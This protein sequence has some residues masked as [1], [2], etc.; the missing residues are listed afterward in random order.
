MNKA[1][2]FWNERRIQLKENLEQNRLPCCVAIP[3]SKF[4]ENV[5]G[6]IRTANAFLIKEIVL[7]HGVYNKAAT[8]GTAKWEN[9]EITQ[10]VFGY[11]K[12]QGYKSVA[13]EQ[14]PRS[15]PIWDFEFP[16]NTA[17]FI[18]HEV[19]GMND[20]M[21]EKCDYVIEIPQFGLVESLNV[22]TATSI[23]LYEYS[24]QHRK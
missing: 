20:E 9:I 8:A 22:A 1:L 19:H 23:A 13:L 11:V 5:G 18:G 10:D 3:E 4:I 6:I 7:D 16:D 2:K 14:H 15:V 24:R 21:V 12:E 17:I